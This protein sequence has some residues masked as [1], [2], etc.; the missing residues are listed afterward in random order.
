MP[1][2]LDD[3]TRTFLEAPHVAVLATVSPGGRPQATPVWY[4]LDGDEIVI[5]TSKGRVKLRNLEKNPRVALTVVDAKDMY[6]YVQIQGRVVRF[7]QEHGARDIDRLS[8]RYRGRPYTYPGHDRPEN[9]VTL[10]IRPLAVS[11]MGRR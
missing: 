10:V 8:M 4:L 9:R 11:G 1:V 2:A 7:D 3:A 6:H 5:N